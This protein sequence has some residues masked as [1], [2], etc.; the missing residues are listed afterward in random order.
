MVVDIYHDPCPGTHTLAEVGFHDSRGGVLT[1]RQVLSITPFMYRSPATSAIGTAASSCSISSFVSE[2]P[3]ESM[4]ESKFT[5]F[6]VPETK[7]ATPA[8]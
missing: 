8:E 7:Q 2:T 3:S 4:F 1:Y 5:I 6:V